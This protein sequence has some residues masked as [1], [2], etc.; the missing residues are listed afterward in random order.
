MQ[1]DAAPKNN[2]QQ[3]QQRQQQQNY[4]RPR[5]Y[6]TGYQPCGSMEDPPNNVQ[7]LAVSRCREQHPP[8]YQRA[9]QALQQDIMPQQ[10]QFEYSWYYLDARG[11]EFGPLPSSAMRELY[12]SGYFP[13]GRALLVRM[14][15]WSHPMPVGDIWP[16][17]RS[18]PFSSFGDSPSPQVRSGR[19]SR[20]HHFAEQPCMQPDASLDFVQDMMPMESSQFLNHRGRAYPS[21]GEQPSPLAPSRGGRFVGPSG[22]NS[23]GGPCAG[24]GCW[25]HG[26]GPAP[27]APGN[28]DSVETSLPAQPDPW[29]ENS[30]EPAL[31]PMRARLSLWD[32]LPNSGYERPRGCPSGGRNSLQGP[33]QHHQLY[34]TQ[35]HQ[36]Q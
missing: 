16:D 13:P 27:S 1:Q 34:P 32:D 8:Q 29:L 12:E 21:Y 36:H 18:H 19:P 22:P 30:S 26:K 31:A 14:P 24:K 20:R 2:R 17:G 3:R 4:S 6:G 23:R 9:R 28:R 35:K 15:H 11:Q 7:S 10:Q 33:R 5:T 25:H